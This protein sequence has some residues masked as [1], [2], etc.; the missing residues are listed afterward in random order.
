M[1]NTILEM[2]RNKQ[3]EIEL[4]DKAIAKA[5]GFKE[6]NVNNHLNKF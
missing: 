4:L 2:L 3:E 6:N 1:S 5:I